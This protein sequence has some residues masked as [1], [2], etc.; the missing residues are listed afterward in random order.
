M[1]NWLLRLWRRIGAWM[2]AQQPRLTR[3]ESSR[4]RCS[5][6]VTS[7]AIGI[8][9]PFVLF[10]TQRGAVRSRFALRSD[11]YWMAVEYSGRI[12]TKERRLRLP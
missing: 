1:L 9:V 8:R 7:A 12:L 4:A 10:L 5:P 6:K 3:T 11:V 2:H